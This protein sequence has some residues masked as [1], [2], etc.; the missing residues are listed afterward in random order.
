M[1]FRGARMFETRDEIW[2]TDSIILDPAQ[3]AR[4]DKEKI[5]FLADDILANGLHQRIGVTDKKLC[6][7]GTGRAL[8]L[9]LAGI[10]QAPVKVYLG[11]TPSQFAQIGLAENFLREDLTD[12]E[13]VHGVIEFMKLNPGM[14][15]KDCAAKLHVD[16]SSVTRWF[17]YL[18]ATP[19]TR[20][21]FDSGAINL[22]QM[23]AITKQEDKSLALAQALNGSGRDAIEADGRKRRNGQETDAEQNKRRRIKLPM[24]GGAVVAVAAKAKEPTGKELIQALQG[25]ITDCQATIR[26]I[27][28][29]EKEGISVA[30]IQAGIKDKSK[31]KGGT[32]E[33]GTNGQPASES[34]VD[35]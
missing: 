10:K 33:S 25:A 19:E 35:G 9:M 20:A 27:R 16:A 4:H 1:R 23:Y 30:S 7:Y 26:Y 5:R 14:T 2:P 28:E 21:A 22:T 13:K 6:A 8:A 11:V 15:R 29:A 32:G 17:S 3:V 18:D 31:L 34:S 12:Q 24:P